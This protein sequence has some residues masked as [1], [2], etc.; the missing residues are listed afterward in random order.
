MGLIS[1]VSSRTYRHLAKIYPKKM[2]DAVERRASN[3]TSAAE[4]HLQNTYQLKPDFSRKFK[5]KTATD[6][7]NKQLEQHLDGHNYESLV[8]WHDENSNAFPDWL[9][10]EIQASLVRSKLFDEHYKYACHVQLIQNAGATCTIKA[11]CLW[12]GDNDGRATASYKTDTYV[13]L[14]NIFAYYFY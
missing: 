9:A 3:A 12:D 7:I 4:S 14:V 2:A 10:N 1:R 8:E 5:P 6:L 13:I 11:A